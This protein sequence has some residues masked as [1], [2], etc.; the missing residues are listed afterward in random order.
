MKKITIWKSIKQKIDEN[1]EKIEV[2]SY[3]HFEN[4]WSS[5]NYPLQFDNKFANQ[6]DWKKAKWIKEFAFLD[7]NVVVY[8]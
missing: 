4:G 3:N 8:A 1:K 5:L 2:V 7:N 6:V